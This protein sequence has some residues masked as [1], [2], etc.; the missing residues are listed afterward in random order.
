MKLI[1]HCQAVKMIHDRWSGR[2]LP[3]VWV[4]CGSLGNGCQVDVYV[5][6]SGGNQVAGI[7]LED[8]ESYL[9]VQAV[10]PGTDAG[11]ENSKHFK[12][13]G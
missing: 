11:L 6:S 5:S 13:P 3:G 10:Y 7:V 1:N 9:G 12:F 4:V 2:W 8:L